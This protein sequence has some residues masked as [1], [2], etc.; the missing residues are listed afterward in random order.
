M[1]HAPIVVVC[2]LVLYGCAIESRI[3]WPRATWQSVATPTKAMNQ[4]MFGSSIAMTYGVL[5]LFN[6][7]YTLFFAVVVVCGIRGIGWWVAH[8]RRQARASRATFPPVPAQRTV[9]AVA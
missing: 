4:F 5:M 6:V 2:L 9:G 3:D 1:K 8:L 7:V